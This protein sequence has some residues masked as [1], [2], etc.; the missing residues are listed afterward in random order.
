MLR[1]EIAVRSGERGAGVKKGKKEREIGKKEI[2]KI[3]HRSQGNNIWPVNNDG[4]AFLES[5]QRADVAQLPCQEN[6]RT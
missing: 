5:M 4:V 3:S 2:E 6:T 1:A